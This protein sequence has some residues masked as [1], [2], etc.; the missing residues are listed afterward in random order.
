MH[1]LSIAQNILEIA[2]EEAGRQGHARVEIVHL[3]VGVLSGVVEDALLFAWEVASQD[4]AVAGSRLE[5]ET[6]PIQVRCPRC[7][8]ESTLGEPLA[9]VCPDCGGAPVEVLH[10]TELELTALELSDP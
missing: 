1:E 9:L 2:C 4:T 8:A 5:I 10:G 3:R 7:H 6:V